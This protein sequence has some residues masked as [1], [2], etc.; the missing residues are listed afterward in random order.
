MVKLTRI[1]TFRDFSSQYGREKI[2]GSSDMRYRFSYGAHSFGRAP[3]VSFC[4]YGFGQ[5]ND[6]F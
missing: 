3:V 2:I 4:R 1:Y 5:G 6:A